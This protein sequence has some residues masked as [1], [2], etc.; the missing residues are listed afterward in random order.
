MLANL[1]ISQRH[2]I[3]IHYIVTTYIFFLTKLL[4]GSV[5]HSLPL[6]GVHG[7]KTVAR[8]MRV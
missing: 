6:D 7:P 3:Q 8:N 1:K 4:N 5:Q 2:R